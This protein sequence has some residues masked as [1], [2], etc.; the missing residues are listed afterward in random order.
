VHNKCPKIC[1]IV[2]LN[3]AEKSKFCGLAQNSATSGKLCALIISELC[4]LVLDLILRHHDNVT[5]AFKHSVGAACPQ[6]E[7]GENFVKGVCLYNINCYH[8]EAQF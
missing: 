4:R 3:F 2:G 6:S 8:Q 7:I 5:E 1:N